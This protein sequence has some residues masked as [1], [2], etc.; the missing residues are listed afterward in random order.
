M[1]DY[2]KRGREWLWAWLAAV[3]LLAV[4]NIIYRIKGTDGVFAS[5]YSSIGA[6]IGGGLFMLTKFFTYRKM[7]PEQFA[8][9]QKKERRNYDERSRLIS[10]RACGLTLGALATALCAGLIVGDALNNA[11]MQIYSL[12]LMVLLVV[13]LLVS[14]AVFKRKM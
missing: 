11:A 9:S 14:E 8:E 6:A 12:V 4:L 10:G 7:T 5:P 13:V 1:K 3:A 2:R